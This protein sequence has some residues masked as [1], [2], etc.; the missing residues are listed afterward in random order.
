MH[1][2]IFVIIQKENKYVA[3]GADLNSV[4]KEQHKKNGDPCKSNEKQQQKQ[5]SPTQ[6][7]DVFTSPA[8]ITPHNAHGT[9][10][11]ALPPSGLILDLYYC[12]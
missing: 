5:Q 12:Y 3:G 4:A 10:S 6:S 11:P 9:F 8:C 2:Q 1:K 7:T